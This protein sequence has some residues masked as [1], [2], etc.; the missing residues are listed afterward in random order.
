MMG[1]LIC[2]RKLRFGTGLGIKMI[3][4]FEKFILL[5]QLKKKIYQVPLIPQITILF[6]KCT[7]ISTCNDYS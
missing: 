2:F 1:R 7:E 3:E 5:K 4:W 6:I